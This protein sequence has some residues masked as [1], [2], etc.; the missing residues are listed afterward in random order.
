MMGILV[1][2]EI[3][4]RAELGMIEPF[5]DGQVRELDGEQVISFGLS[6]CGYDIRL[7][8]EILKPLK[9]D[10]LGKVVLDPR[11]PRKDKW[12]K[13]SDGKPYCIEPGCFVLGRSVE[14]V[15]MPIDI[16]G[17]CVGKSTYARCGVLANITPLE[18]GWEGFI[19]LELSNTGELPVIIYPNM[20]IAQII[21]HRTD[22]L[23]DHLYTGRYQGQRE[24]TLAHV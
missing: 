3:R 19:T 23:C 4:K 8:E 11:K 10:G 22:S 17:I 2:W 20:G 5:I 1:D 21:F 7:A 12:F 16:I 24:V 14:Y 6:S 18:P 15:R 13:I 9:F